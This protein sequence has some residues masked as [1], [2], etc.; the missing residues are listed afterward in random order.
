[1]KKIIIPML[2]L[3]L[4]LTMIH[5]AHAYSYTAW[6]AMTG[7]KTL[8]IN[9]FFYGPIKGGFGL[10]TDL[11]ISY[12]FTSN[13]DVIADLASL[14]LY[15]T[16]RYMGSY[17]M[18]RFDLGKN[19]ILALQLN[20]VNT[21]PLSYSVSPQ[22]HFFYENDTLAFELNLGATV[23]FSTPDTSTLSGVVV[24]VY[25]IVK[26]AFHLFFEID[27]SYTLGNS[28]TFNL[29]L[30]PG[31]CILLAGGKHQICLGVPLSGVTSSSMG[32]GFGTW[33]WTTFSL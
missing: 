4:S 24:P 14:S 2:A 25:K 23:P 11:V 19:N 1:M 21:D 33:Y 9:P 6:G 7:A 18:P 20:V 5:G 3:L 8:A 31:V 10:N 12:G 28:G 27:P 15:S 13:F 16:S 30:V 29:N 26:G 32:V 22:Y 17:I